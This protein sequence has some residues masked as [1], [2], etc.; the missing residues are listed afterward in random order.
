MATIGIFM[1]F[2]DGIREADPEYR[3][4]H[5]F[6]L[7]ESLHLLHLQNVDLEH[8][9]DEPPWNVEEECGGLPAHTVLMK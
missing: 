9:L 8:A 5:N 6:E 7:S 2:P 3:R 1:P 4:A